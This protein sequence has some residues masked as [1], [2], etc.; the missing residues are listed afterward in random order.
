MKLNYKYTIWIGLAI[1]FLFFI[2]SLTVAYKTNW[3]DPVSK[4]FGKLYPAAIVG[5]KL[6]SVEDANEFV[7]LARGMDNTVSPQEAFANFLQR[8]KQQGLLDKLGI[9]LASDAISDEKDFYT[10]GNETVYREFIKSY[11]HGDENLFTQIVVYPEVVEAN[12]RMFY[13]SQFDLN[14]DAYAKAEGILDQLNKGAKF[15]DLAKTYSDDRETAQLGGDLGFFA[16]SQILPEL[17]KEITIARAGQV[18]NKII[19][20]RNGYEIIYPIEVSNQNGTKLWHAKHILIQTTGFDA[21]VKSQT[22]QI[23]IKIL[24]RY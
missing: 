7:E 5:N 22:D 18:E 24:K 8:A 10:K 13:N 6:I 19:V 17:E 9:R 16:H 20:T 1:I 2:V 21:W 11:F 14:K 15:E 4:S 12:L 3:S 23:K